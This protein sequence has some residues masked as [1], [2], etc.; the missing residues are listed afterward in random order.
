[1]LKNIA[2]SVKSPVTIL[3]THYF[4]TEK[5]KPIIPTYSPISAFSSNPTF[6]KSLSKEEMKDLLM[7]SSATFPNS[8]VSLAR[9]SNTYK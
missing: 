1:M 9:N 6:T 4:T 8:H 5:R 7:N 2:I 3:V